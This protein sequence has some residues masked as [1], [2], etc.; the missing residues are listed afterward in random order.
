MGA[1]GVGGEEELGQE[2]EVAG[3]PDVAVVDAHEGYDAEK[4]ADHGINLCLLSCQDFLR[5]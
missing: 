1:V 2:G 4:P 3:A 5:C